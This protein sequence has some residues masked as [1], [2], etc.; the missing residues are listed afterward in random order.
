MTSSS[1]KVTSR[2]L[3]ASAGALSV[4]AGSLGT[5]PAA[6]ANAPTEQLGGGARQEAQQPAQQQQQQP[7]QQQGQANQ[8]QQPAQQQQKQGQAGNQQQGQGQAEQSKDLAGQYQSSQSA[9][10]AKNNKAWKTYSS[11]DSY[12]AGCVTRVNADTQQ[13]EAT[14]QLPGATQGSSSYSI[15]IDDVNGTVW[16]VNTE[17]STVT[18]YDQNTMKELWTSN[19]AVQGAQGQS[20]FQAREIKI[21]QDSGKA[22]ISSYGYVT[23]IDLQTRAVVKTIDLKTSTGQFDI[24]GNMSFSGGKLFAYGQ[25][26]GALIIVN[27]VTLQV[28]SASQSSG[29][30]QQPSGGASSTPTVNN[31]QANPNQGGNQADPNQGGNQ[32]DPNQGG[33]QAD[34]NKG[35]NQADPNKGGNQADPNKGGNQA[36]PNKGGNQANPN[37]GGNQANPNKGGNQADPNQGGNNVV[38]EVDVHTY[39]DGA[40]VYI[41]EQWQVGQPLKIRGEGFKT[42]D[43]TSGSV[44]AVKL[45]GGSLAPAQDATFEGKKGNSAGVWLYIQADANGNFTAELPF[46]SADKVKGGAAP[47][48][49]DEVSVNLLS[50]SMKKGDTPRGGEANDVTIV[51]G[52]G[53]N[54]GGNNAGGGDNAKAGANQGGGNNAGGN[55]NAGGGNN[56]GGGDNANAGG[57]VNAGDNAKAGGNNA[58]GGDNAKAGAN[59]GGG[60]NAGGNVNAGGGD[61][62]KAGGN[63]AGGGDNAKAGANQGGGNNA[64]DNAKAGGNANAADNA[65]AGANQGGNQAD[66]GNNAGAN[67]PAQVA[68]EET[69]HTYDDGAKV[70][71]PKNWQVG[72]SLKIRGEGFKTQDGTSGS[73]IAV[74]LNGGSLAPAQDATFEGKKGNSAGV[75]L[76]IQADANGNFTAEIPFPSADKVKGDAPKVGEKVAINLLSGSMKKG[77]NARGGEAA[78]VTITE[79]GANAGGNANAGDNANANANAGGNAN[80]NAGGNANANAGADANANGAAKGDANGIAAAK[81]NDHDSAVTGDSTTTTSGGST[82]TTS[83]EARGSGSATTA[84]TKSSSRTLANTGAS[85]MW[86]ALGAGTAALVAGSVMVARRRTSA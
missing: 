52:G 61:N 81:D 68:V 35:G 30:S 83:G 44:I 32:A 57:N 31:N 39:D 71:I 9:Y 21:D 20:S 41:P 77:D 75:W 76:Y 37:K 67:D 66:P 72:Q 15:A 34:P 42:Q 69:V 49:G 4:V 38:G 14:V 22:Y 56:A 11:Y 59:Q 19:G 54:A 70:Y 23:V 12:R 24:V 47:N 10:S 58:G 60:N 43:G 36:D 25:N 28:E 50:G 46:P 3:L 2:K 48:V 51:A 16:V 18:V 55:V 8:Q 40:K 27:T 6:F 79:G 53:N 78:E 5:I 26:S 82:G 63:N 62:A 86:V 29:A 13:V 17:K 84:A 45:N 64:G 33:N 74:K 80:A 7:A 65:N 1:K 85:G 73:V